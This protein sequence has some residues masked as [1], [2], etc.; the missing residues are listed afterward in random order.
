MSDEEAA[1]EK[2]LRPASVASTGDCRAR[3]QAMHICDF[4]EGEFDIQVNGKIYHFEMHKICGPTILKRNG[5][6]VKH[7]PPCFLFAA[8][9]WLQN[10]R[11]I[12]N[13]LCVWFHEPKPILKHLGGKHFLING[14]LAAVRGS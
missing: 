7:Q 9:Q 2:D 4:S 3:R 5:D 11:Q 8:S 13:G 6:P 1:A 10:G 12:E 14:E